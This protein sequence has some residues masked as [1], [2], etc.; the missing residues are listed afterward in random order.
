MACLKFG[1]KKL[2]PHQARVIKALFTNFSIL[3]AH[4]TGTGKTLTAISAA[5]CLL[6][7]KKVTHVVVATPRALVHNFWNELL[8]YGDF[9]DTKKYTVGTYQSIEKLFKQNPNFFKNALLIVDEAHNLRTEYKDVSKSGRPAKGK[10]AR[11][12][13]KMS[14][15]VKKVLLLTATPVINYIK[16]F[17]NLYNMLTE[18]KKIENVFDV[19]DEDDCPINITEFPLVDI[20]KRGGHDENFPAVVRRDE[21]MIMTGEYLKK[22]KQ[23]EDRIDSGLEPF[24]FFM[25][26]RALLNKLGDEDTYKIAF[27]LEN[28]L[29]NKNLKTVVFSQFLTNGIHLITKVLDKKKIP[30]FLITGNTKGKDI[31]SAVENF[32]NRTRGGILF[33]SKAGGEGLDLKGVRKMILLEPFWNESNETQAVGRAVRFKSHS[34]LPSNE[35]KVE[36]IRIVL[37]KPKQKF[38]QIKKAK[39]SADEYLVDLAKKKQKQIE[40]FLNCLE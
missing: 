10:M 38:W 30:Y 18:A 37:K 3:A 26:L 16:E 20:H 36:I 14:W 34:H 2:R 1:N 28:L 23:L 27:V 13:I 6:Y 25:K 7:T 17:D 31:K 12:F 40:L 24:A 4:G 32:N 33:I 22:Y 8:L 15:K 9:V 5:E 19:L 35:R 11:N 21:V 29:S 39:Q